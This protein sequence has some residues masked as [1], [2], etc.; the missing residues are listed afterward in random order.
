MVMKLTKPQTIALKI[1]TE[2]KIRTPSEYARIRFEGTR[3]LSR[4][5]NVGI[6]GA[7]TGVLANLQGGKMLNKLKGLG[8][9]NYGASYDDRSL[10]TLTEL[11]SELL[12][13]SK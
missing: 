6:N 10:I 5:T 12:N 9:I 2:N 1:I 4:S 3:L 7:T 8:Y 13:N 11:G